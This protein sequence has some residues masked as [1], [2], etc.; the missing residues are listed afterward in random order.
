MPETVANLR[1]FIAV[2]LPD[3][4]RAN[5]ERPYRSLKL[6]LAGDGVRWT[7]LKQVHLTLK[8]LGDVAADSLA[9]LRAA[10]ERGCRGVAPFSLRA[11]ALG[12]FPSAQRPRV[13]WCGVT[14]ELDMLRQ[15]QEQI[16][17]E[18]IIWREREARPFQPHLTLARIKVLGPGRAAALRKKREAL[19][20]ADFGAWPVGRVDLMQCH[21]SATG[22][23]HTR[24]AEFP[25]SLSE[26]CEGVLR[27]GI[28]AVGKGGEA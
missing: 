28:L 26:N 25:L 5:L 13:V 20:A 9:D 1:L 21:L 3:D 22:V 19:A 27:R 10:V 6:A 14:G 24:L 23:T 16:E 8:F 4:L 15:L 12:V 7:P 2:N 17:N 11:H 18:T